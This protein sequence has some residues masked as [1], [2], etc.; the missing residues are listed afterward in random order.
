MIELRL[1]RD[2]VG[3]GKMLVATKVIDDKEYNIIT[4]ENYGIQP[5]Q[6]TNVK[7]GQAN[8]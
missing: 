8:R 7:G 1:N 4:L 5:V 2:G 6:L 3:E